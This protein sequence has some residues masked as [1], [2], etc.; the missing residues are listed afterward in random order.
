LDH[1]DLGESVG[2]KFARV[3]PSR[4]MGFILYQSIAE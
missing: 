4:A 3:Q 2:V 1:A